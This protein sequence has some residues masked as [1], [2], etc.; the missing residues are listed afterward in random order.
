MQAAS[1]KKLPMYESIRFCSVTVYFKFVLKI[2]KNVNIKS[3]KNS[4]GILGM[5]AHTYNACSW[6]WK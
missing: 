1:K 2:F 5:V 4:S 6:G 3:S